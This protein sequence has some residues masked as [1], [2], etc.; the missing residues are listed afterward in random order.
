MHVFFL[1]FNS[2]KDFI[3]K[4]KIPFL[5]HILKWAYDMFFLLKIIV[6]S[7]THSF[8]VIN[9]IR[10]N[11]MANSTYAWHVVYYILFKENLGKYQQ[12]QQIPYLIAINEWVACTHLLLHILKNAFFRQLFGKKMVVIVKVINIFR[13]FKQTK[14]AWQV[15]R[16]TSTC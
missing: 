5:L 4:L 7:R 12:C 15:V 9:Q 8:I 3:F 14:Y 13:K 6:I 2:S 10:R 16:I 11:S 1:G